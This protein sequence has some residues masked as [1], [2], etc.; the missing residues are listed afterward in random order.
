MD[1][2]SNSAWDRLLA[3]HQ[4]PGTSNGSV[5]PHFNGGTKNNYKLYFLTPL[6]Y[7][8][9]VRRPF[10]SR[11]TARTT[12]TDRREVWFVAHN[13]KLHRIFSILT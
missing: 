2:P 5:G 4:G 13:Y 6:Y 11:K 9:I 1:S 7:V 8:G 10:S 3:H 12:K